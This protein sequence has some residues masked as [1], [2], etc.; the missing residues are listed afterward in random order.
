MQSKLKKHRPQMNSFES[1]KIRKQKKR[2]KKRLKKEQK[3]G[4]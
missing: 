4:L 1:E 3:K 2:L